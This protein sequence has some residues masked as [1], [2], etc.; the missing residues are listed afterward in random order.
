MVTEGT[1]NNDS[2]LEVA[3][4]TVNRSAILPDDRHIIE[5]IKKN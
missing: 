1:G 3:E 5:C 4:V 2:Y